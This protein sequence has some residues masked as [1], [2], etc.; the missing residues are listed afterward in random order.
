MIDVFCGGGMVEYVVRQEW[1]QRVHWQRL[2]YT[3]DPGTPGFSVLEMWGRNG[4]PMRYSFQ[5]DQSGRLVS[6]YLD[7]M[8]R[9]ASLTI[10]DVA[11]DE[12]GLI[13]GLLNVAGNVRISSL[14]LPSQSAAALVQEAHVEA[15]KGAGEHIS[16]PAAGMVYVA[17]KG[18][19][20]RSWVHRENSRSG[21]NARFEQRG[22]DEAAFTWGNHV[23]MRVTFD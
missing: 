12:R 16:Q 22:P 13:S 2:R 9:T 1:S 10:L 6:R 21:F 18:F 4:E 3:T 20:M 5:F 7:H 19:K 15:L 14:A 17:D 11:F 23:Q 8:G